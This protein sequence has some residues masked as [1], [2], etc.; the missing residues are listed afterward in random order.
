MAKI[1]NGTQLA[2]T[3]ADG[4]VKLV[5]N[6]ARQPKLVIFAVAPE[7]RSQIYIDAKLK[8][9]QQVGIEAELVI[10]DKITTAKLI[11]EIEQAAND[12]EIDGIMVQ[13][14]LPKTI[15]K[16]KV[17][18]VIPADKDVD[19]LRFLDVGA[20]RFAPATALAVLAALQSSGKTPRNSNVT[21]VGQGE[22]GKPLAAILRSHNVKVTTVAKPNDQL[23][24]KTKNADIVIS[25]VGSPRL[26][27]SSHIKTG[28]AVIDVGVSIVDGKTIGD[29]SFDEVSKKA[30][31][32]TPVIG[33][34][35]PVTVA[36]LLQNV[37]AA[38]AQHQDKSAQ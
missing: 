33:G 34:I 9:A 15:A 20:S 4:L 17:L 11:A 8:R 14:P 35:G 6:L 24:S 3:I 22:V 2:D 28:A 7:K 1:F 30:S 5:A 19:G 10:H 16:S 25:A 32:V 37:I 21:I 26:I 31:F 38:A 18:D 23:A 13:L 12:A 27:T 36:M 29:V